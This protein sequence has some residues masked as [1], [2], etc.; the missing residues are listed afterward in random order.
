MA[1]TTKLSINDPITG[2]F[3]QLDGGMQ[4]QISVMYQMLVEMRVMNQFLQQMVNP[5]ED[6][7]QNQRADQSVAE[8]QFANVR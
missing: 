7:T 6:E 2:G 1:G 3:I 8:P 5:V 4:S